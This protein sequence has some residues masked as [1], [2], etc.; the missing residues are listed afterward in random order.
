VSHSER[1]QSGEHIGLA[2]GLPVRLGRQIRHRENTGVHR[3]TIIEGTVR[4]QHLEDVAE[5]PVHLAA[6]PEDMMRLPNHLHQLGFG[7]VCQTLAHQTAQDSTHWNPFEN[8]RCP[9]HAAA[10]TQLLP[11]RL[12]D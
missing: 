7:E 2:D 9:P 6:I 3:L 8:L 1:I 12:Q 4:E 5:Q 10:R 11:K